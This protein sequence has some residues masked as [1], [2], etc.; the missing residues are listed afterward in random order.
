MRCSRTCHYHAHT[1]LGNGSIAPLSSEVKSVH[2]NSVLYVTLQTCFVPI[3]HKT[4]SN[5]MNLILE[6]TNRL[7]FYT[8]MR[9]VFTALGIAASDYDWFVSD[10]ET[11]YYG[12][13]FSSENRWIAGTDLE[14]FLNENEVQF[15]WAVFSAVPKGYRAKIT[16]PPYAD[17]NPNYWN[18]KETMPQLENALFEIACWDSS[19]TILVGLPPHLELNFKLVYPETCSLISAAR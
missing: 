7:P 13:G 1:L 19:A 15:I 12:I 10:I 8:N 11:N 3:Y 2:E 17:G 16:T 18:G 9:L 14:L 5:F 6:R 4:H